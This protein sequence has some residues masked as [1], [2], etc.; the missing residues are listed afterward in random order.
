MRSLDGILAALPAS[1]TEGALLDRA[2]IEALLP[3]RDPFL[4]LDAV[5]E[6]G[7]G[8]I[9]AQK[10]IRPDEPCFAGHFPGDPIFPGVLQIEAMAQAMAA[11]MTL[12]NPEF[13]GRRPLFLGVD[14]CRFRKPV[15]P[16]DDLRV[17]AKILRISR[18]VGICSAEIRMDGNLVSEATLR[19]SLAP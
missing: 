13:R 9:V 8:E 14:D 18:N 19:A 3:H 15:R 4:M 17:H 2:G 5:L 6:L 10:R 16:G 7:D 11:L 1:S 12:S